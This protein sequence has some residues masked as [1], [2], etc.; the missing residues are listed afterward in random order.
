M[1]DYLSRYLLL[2]IAQG[3]LLS[4]GAIAFVS[5]REQSVSAAVYLGSCTISQAIVATRRVAA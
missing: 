2:H 1:L 3:V 5:G 4:L